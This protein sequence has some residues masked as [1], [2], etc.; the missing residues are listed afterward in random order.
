MDSF[1]YVY[2]LRSEPDRR[3]Y[4]GRTTDL[5][6]RMEYHRRGYVHSTRHRRPVE[7]ILYEAFPTRA[8]ATRR[9][10][11]LKT[12]KGKVMLRAILSS[13]LRT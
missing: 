10:R 4:V 7:L 2:V 6:Q 1:T 8:D 13:F 9:E 5:R 11:Y 3:L 12:T